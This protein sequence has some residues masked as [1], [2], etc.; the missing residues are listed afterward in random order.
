MTKIIL[1]KCYYGG[2]DLC[3]NCGGS[4]VTILHGK[5]DYR[6]LKKSA[7]ILPKLT[8]GSTLT[9]SEKVL[10]HVKFDTDVIDFFNRNFYRLENKKKTKLIEI[11]NERLENWEIQSLSIKDN[12]LQDDILEYIPELRE[13]IREFLVRIE[14]SRNV[15]PRKRVI[16]T[17]SRRSKRKRKESSKVKKVKKNGYTKPKQRKAHKKKK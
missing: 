5:N 9:L 4:G 15:K 8:T 1:C 17:S 10:K 14:N 3:P 13:N 2:Y 16:S 7:E 6:P 12:I 11:L